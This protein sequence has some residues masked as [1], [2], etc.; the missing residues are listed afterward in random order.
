MSM[1]PAGPAPAQAGPPPPTGGGAKPYD[2][3]KCAMDAQ[4]A[5]EKLNT[6]LGKADAP[7]NVIKAVGGMADAIRRI[8]DAMAQ[9][10][11]PGG[12]QPPPAQPRETMQTATNALASQ[13]RRP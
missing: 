5:L 1:M 8:A 7:P 6:E 4:S 13:A 3:H 10:P 12:N 11:S 9:A 2:I